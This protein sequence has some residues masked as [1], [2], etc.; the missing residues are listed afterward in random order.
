MNQDGHCGCSVR[1][2]LT[3]LH[4]DNHKSKKDKANWKMIIQHRTIASEDNEEVDY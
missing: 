4:L 2:E 3:D 1:T